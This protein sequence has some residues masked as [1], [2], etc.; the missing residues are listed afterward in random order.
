[1]GGRVAMA[2]HE[3]REWQFALIDDIRTRTGYWLGWAVLLV[4][5]AGVA[6]SMLM[7]R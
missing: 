3:R 6:A 4:A 5:G 7:P 1:M 2:T